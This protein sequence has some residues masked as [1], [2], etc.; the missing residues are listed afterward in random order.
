MRPS[1]YRKEFLKVVFSYYNA[2]YQ[3]CPDWG[4]IYSHI[5]FHTN[6]SWSCME[7]GDLTL[8]YI[9]IKPSVGKSNNNWL[10]WKKRLHQNPWK[11]QKTPQPNLNKKITSENRVIYCISPS[12]LS[13]HLSLTN[14]EGFKFEVNWPIVSI[15][16]TDSIS[17]FSV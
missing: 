9:K 8:K 17:I 2:T 12:C 4:L 13:L 15:Y 14:N 16:Y 3:S 10:S 6:F 7:V 1:L 5:D 11:L